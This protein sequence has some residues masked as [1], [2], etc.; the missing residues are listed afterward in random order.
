M[1][2]TGG[3]TVTVHR[4]K[5]DRHGDKADTVIGTICGCV[6]QP[7]TG[8]STLRY[9]T[10]SGFEETAAIRTMLWAPRDAKIKLQDRDRVVLNGRKYRVIGDRAWD[11]DHPVTGTRF[12]HYA[13]EI[14]GVQ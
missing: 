3:I 13:V 1:R 11:D 8:L 9:E 12:S 2:V 6:F 7:S 5:R 10:G 4:A 14:E